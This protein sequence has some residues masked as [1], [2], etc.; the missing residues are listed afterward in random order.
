ML[1]AGPVTVLILPTYRI[2]VLPVG[3]LIEY[4]VAPIG[5]RSVTTSLDSLVPVLVPDV[6]VFEVAK[7]EKP[8]MSKLAVRLP[9]VV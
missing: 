9:V 3:M 5:T 8:V 2:L 1:L 4:G 7:F 6:T